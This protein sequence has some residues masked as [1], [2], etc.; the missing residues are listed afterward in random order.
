VA[1]IWIR[2][3]RF[4]SGRTTSWPFMAIVVYLVQDLA[5]EAYFFFGIESY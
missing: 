3:E 2:L 1:L 5:I 4:P